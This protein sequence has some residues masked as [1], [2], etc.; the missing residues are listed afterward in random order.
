MKIENVLKKFGDE[1]L[2]IKQFTVNADKPKKT[3]KSSSKNIL[4][5]FKDK[6][7]KYMFMPFQV[8]SEVF[9]PKNSM[10]ESLGNESIGN[11]LDGD[12]IIKKC[13]GKK[14]KRKC[15]KKAIKKTCRRKGNMRKMC[16][17]TLKKQLLK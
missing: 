15:I 7:T 16:K 4:V 6:M 14:N 10:N 12:E 13:S 9:M 2:E 5:D 17:R 11:N 1:K 8:F 3:N